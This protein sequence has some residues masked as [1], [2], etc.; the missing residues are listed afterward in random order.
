[1]ISQ[2]TMSVLFGC[3]SFFIHSIIV[4]VAWKRIYGKR[5]AF[6]QI[7]CIFLHD[8]GHLGLN[9]LDDFEAKKKHWMLGASIAYS[10]FGQ[11]GFDFL[12]GH[13]SHSGHPLSELYRADKYSWHIAP[14]WWLYTNTFAEPKL[15]MGYTRRE[16]ILKFKEQV[17]QSVESG[18]FRSTHEMFLERC[19]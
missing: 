14:Y 6:W 1:M 10:L 12:A 3:H 18:E 13:C 4:I 8:V 17:R 11:K 9:Y 16:A 15:R 19:K 2:G 7:V 5:P